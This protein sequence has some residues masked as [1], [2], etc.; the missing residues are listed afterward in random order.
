M[1]KQIRLLL[2]L[3]LALTALVPCSNQISLAGPH[4]VLIPKIN[5][6]ETEYDFGVIEEGI[7]VR[8]SFKIENLGKK[9][10]LITTAYATCGCTVPNIKKKRIAPGESAEMEVVMDT[11]MKQGDVKKAIEV[12]CNDPVTPVS[13]VYVKAKVT[14]PHANMGKDPATKIFSGRCAACHVE[15]GVGKIGEDLFFAD[16]SMC[17][18]FRAKGIPAVAPALVPFDYHDKDI[19]A[20]KRQVIAEG[21]KFHRS[22]PGYAKASGGPLTDK[23]IDSLIEYLKWKSDLELKNDNLLPQK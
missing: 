19:A 17:H 16:C 5:F 23:E 8:H 2:I 22:M 3:I 11:S 1:Q 14:S 4:I 6:P 12:R 9:T 13:T 10:L 15:Q 21:S 7:E 18:G 20:A